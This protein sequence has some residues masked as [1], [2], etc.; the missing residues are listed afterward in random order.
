MLIHRKKLGVYP[1]ITFAVSFLVL[2]LPPRVPHNPIRLRIRP[3]RGT[4]PHNGNNVRG[5]HRLVRVVVYSTVIFVQGCPIHGCRHWAP[6]KNLGTNLVQNGIVRNIVRAANDTKLGDCGVGKDI[7][8]STHLIK[9]MNGRHEFH[10]ASLAC[11]LRYT[12]RIQVRAKAQ[13]AVRTASH[14]RLACIKG[15]EAILMDE[16]IDTRVGSTVTRSRN[17]GTDVIGGG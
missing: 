6:C 10:T 14:V 15:N 3:F 5:I 9:G 1:D 4:V 17:I 16:I 7:N 11:V 8:F 12:C 2:T 13:A